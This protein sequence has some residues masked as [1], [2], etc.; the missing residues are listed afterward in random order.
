MNCKLNESR[1]FQYLGTPIGT[2]AHCGL[3]CAERIIKV[4]R[5]LDAVST[6]P[7]TEVAFKILKSCVNYGRVMHL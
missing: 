6:I 5:V 3:L 7:D 2:L 1:C 4:R